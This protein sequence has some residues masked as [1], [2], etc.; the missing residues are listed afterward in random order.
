MAVRA[1]LHALQLLALMSRQCTWSL[2][3]NATPRISLFPFVR[4]TNGAPLFKLHP[5]PL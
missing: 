1:L 5:A 3:G 2:P 4:L